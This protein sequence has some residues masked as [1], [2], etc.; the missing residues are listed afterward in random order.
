[1]KKLLCLFIAVM[2]VL[3]FGVPSL[4]AE[5]HSFTYDEM[6]A[7]LNAMDIFHG[8][9]T[10]YNFDGGL[11]RAQFTKL[12]IAAS[13]YKTGVPA[14][15]NTSPFA[16]VPRTHWAAG[17]VKVAVTNSVISGYPDSTFRPEG[18]VKTEEAVTILLK[19]MGYT[20]A[21]FGSEWPYGQMG[22]AAN[23][24]LLDD[25]SS[26][27]GAYMKRID[28]VAMIYNM[29]TLKTKQGSSYLSTLGYQMT[30]DAVII[31]SS[32]EDTT[33]DSD[34][35]YTSQGTF[36]VKDNFDFSNVG[37][38]GD[39]LVK[40]ANNEI[41]GFFP[42]QQGVNTYTVES[43]R[44][45]DIWV[46]DGGIAKML[47][48]QSNTTVYEK[49]SKSTLSAMLSQIDEGDRVTVITNEAGNIS[50]MLLG[51]A[52]DKL[53]SSPDAEV[54]A[55]S[56]VIGNDII[57]TKDGVT[58]TLNF[59]STTTAYYN[60][61]KT[62]YSSL[63]SSAN[64]GDTVSVV[65][66]AN[67]KVR[68]VSVDSNKLEGPYTASGSS[69]LSSNG[70]PSDATV[71]KGGVKV[72]AS[73]IKADDIVYYSSTLNTVWVYNEKKTGIYEAASPGI[74]FP[75]SITLSGVS[76]KIETGEAFR[77]L[78]ANGSFTYG[79]TVTLLLGRD[80]KIADVIAPSAG[81]SFAGVVL[82]S[83]T[84]QYTNPS[85]EKYASYFVKIAAADGT[86]YEYATN[87]DYTEYRSSIAKVTFNED[88]SA[89]L[90]KLNETYNISGLFDLTANKLGSSRLARN[91]KIIDI[92]K[93][94][95]SRETEF[96][97]IYGARLDGINIDSKS[98]IYCKKNASGEIE[99][100][101]LSDVTGDLYKYG[102]IISNSVERGG[103]Y[104]CEGTNGSIPSGFSIPSRTPAKLDI[105]GGRVQKAEQ[106][107]RIENGIEGVTESS[108]TDTK[109]NK[110][111]LSDSVNVYLVNYDYEY[112]LIPLK[113]II[114]S[115][116]YTINAFYDKT[117]A[118]GG[119]VRIITVREKK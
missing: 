28:A 91:V 31:A 102:I 9:G 55:V 62:S 47:G 66:D 79:S 74:E 82:S 98:V 46:T 106:L 25:V 93:T 56:A 64:V 8:D 73:D 101:I 16:D 7:M 50:Y 89:K 68:Y 96:I 113:E 88:G 33:I 38:T 42:R 45:E 76:Y 12:A 83:G 30:E 92:K 5:A 81:E 63:A 15:T 58:S 39:M 100:L 67:G 1:M 80:G 40:T 103:Q 85:G 112:M 44:G 71:L 75:E 53:T 70:I 109:G 49:T 27:I 86:L 18:A 108:L 59:P 41:S 116:K 105:S 107:Q 4:N 3:P 6:A 24:G 11:T 114:D 54:Y 51:L 17:Y 69:V 77:K 95:A 57:V 36:K 2:L 118:S 37:R 19:M 111:L 110:Y 117:K 43:V 90:D 35:V 78:A 32:K 60:S 94:D 22:I 99:E 48:A 52:Q 10:G 23:I 115:D 97:R 119:R 29:L 65:K 61:S 84:T 87:K 21:D 26:G 72:S 34:R 13:V 20:N 14:T 104:I